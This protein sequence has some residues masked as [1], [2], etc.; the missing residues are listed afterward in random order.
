MTEIYSQFPRQVHEIGC[1]GISKSYVFRGTKDFSA[2]QVQDMLG[3]GKATAGAP[4]AQPAQYGAHPG[5]QPPGN[6]GPPGAPA[7]PMGAPMAAQ[8][9]PPSRFLQ[10]VQK[11][12]MYLTDLL[13][14]LQRDPWPV[15]QGKRSLRSSGAALSIA[16][17]LLECTFPNTGAR[18]MLFAGGAC[19]QG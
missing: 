6:V 3:L 7:G 17:G 18:I 10:Q 5:M 16:V 15:P 1:D 14:E 11:C 12:D 19:S 4:S 9:V 13:G 8:T 2:K